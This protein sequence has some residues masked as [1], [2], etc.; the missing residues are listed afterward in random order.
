MDIL[1]YQ[2]CPVHHLA[3]KTFLSYA[4]TLVSP[5]A[6]LPIH[7]FHLMLDFIFYGILK[8]ILCLYYRQPVVLPLSKAYPN[9]LCNS[10][11]FFH[12]FLSNLDI[13]K[14]HTASFRNLAF[15]KG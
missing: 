8:T 4:L 6:Q 2:Q 3:D 10:Y 9:I 15:I 13:V 12:N 14:I 1:L 5:D 7:Q 11:R